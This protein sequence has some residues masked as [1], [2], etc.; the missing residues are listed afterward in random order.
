MK[1]FFVILMLT[2][3]VSIPAFA[4]TNF[5]TVIQAVI[6]A[7]L[8]ITTTIPGTKAIDPA[9]TSTTLGNASISS[10]ISSWTITVHST[11]GGKMIRAGGAEEYPYLFTFGALATNHNLASDLVITRTAPQSATNYALSISYT[12]A[13]DIV[14]L[15]PAGTYEDTLSVTLT[16]L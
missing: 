3:L 13:S 1:K 8:S 12:K 10:N 4:A 9:A 15:L 14:P 6:G 7:D 5:Q 11:N 2:V 16:A